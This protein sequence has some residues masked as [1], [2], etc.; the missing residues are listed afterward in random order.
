[1]TKIER[2]KLLLKL[3][4]LIILIICLITLQTKYSSVEVKAT[5]TNSKTLPKQQVILIVQTQTDSPL[6]ISDLRN[7]SDNPLEPDIA[8]NIKNVNSSPITAF[9]IRYIALFD[10]AKSDGVTLNNILSKPRILQPAQFAESLLDSTGY[11][12]PVLE[13]NVA[14]DFVE[15]SDGKIWGDDKFKSGE[16]LAGMRAGAKDET[17]LLLSKLQE[18]GTMSVLDS[19]KLNNDESITVPEV[20][21]SPNWIKGYHEGRNSRRDQILRAYVQGGLNS[22]EQALRQPYDASE[23]GNK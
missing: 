23:G 21:R 8:F 5:E 3:L 13:I 20:G 18:K 15:F 22:I 17:A 2:Q 6:L 14:V 19:L 12:K 10:G 1:M 9:A 4:T 16:R 11:S 7:V